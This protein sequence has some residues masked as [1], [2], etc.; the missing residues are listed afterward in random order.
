MIK[1]RTIAKWFP[2][3][4]ADDSGSWLYRTLREFEDL[5]EGWELVSTVYRPKAI[6][7]HGR[8]VLMCEKLILIFKRGE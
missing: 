7:D 4:D 3:G 5:K 8:D 1:H 2:E 6:G